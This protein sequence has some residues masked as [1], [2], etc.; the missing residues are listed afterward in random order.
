M[1]IKGHAPG[2]ILQFL[3]IR[4]R[5]RKA[6]GTSKKFIDVGSGKGYLSELLLSLGHNGIGVDLNQS[7][8]IHNNLLNSNYISDGKYE[9]VN[10]AF[11]LIDNKD[12]DFLISSM[13]I[14]H[15]DE[16]TLDK[17]M[18]KAKQVIKPNG[19]LIFLVPSNMD[20]WGIEDEIAGHVK[21]YSFSDIE[22]MASKH[23]MNLEKRVGLNYPISNWLLSL[24]NR[25][26]NSKEAEILNKSERDRTIYTGNR[27]I[28]YKTV[29]PTYLNLILNELVMYPF[30]I[31]QNI[32][33]NNEKSLVMYFELTLIN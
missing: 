18:T 3:F 25:I 15:L 8:C 21:R 16:I 32:F 27:N 12:F 33:K 29:Y 30:H 31:L 6:M 19:R 17:F 23:N 7:A 14:E 24:S 1:I 26:V 20:A 5:L 28:K 11:E 13:V 4:D 9:V 10:T 2:T 22:R